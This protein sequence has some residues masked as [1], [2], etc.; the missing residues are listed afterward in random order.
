MKIL[1]LCLS[2]NLGGLELYV[3]KCINELKKDN[4]VLS[5]LKSGGLL[6]SRSDEFVGF[7]KAFHNLPIFSAGKLAKIIDDFEAEVIHI[8]WSKDLFLAVLAKLR[9]KRK[10]KIV[11][12]RQME[13]PAEKK[14]AY[15]NF[16]YSHVDLMLTITKNLEGEAKRYLPESFS[17]KVEALYY[18]V[19]EPEKLLSEEERD[20]T[21]SKYGFSKDDYVVG[22][23]G[24]IEETKGQYLLVD[25]LADLP[26]LKSLIVGRAM[27]EE[28]LVGLKQEAKQMCGDRV[29]FEDFVN[30]PGEIMECC[31][32]V[33]LATKNETFGLVLAEAMLHKTPIIGSNKGGVPEIVGDDESRGLFFES[34]DSQDLKEKI[35]FAYENQDLMN[36]KMERAYTFAKEEFNYDNHYK[37]LNKIFRKLS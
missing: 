32:L 16:V 34:Q 3:E 23:I 28:Y 35:L 4:E 6:A 36:E 31:D 8:H 26:D 18:G 5:V 20:S 24:R 21:R 7:E 27:E 13:I 33:L 15:H 17:S 12:T 25:A 30:N 29:V 19:E 10:P 2:P 9:S 22:L 11:Y 1:E 14:G 37:K